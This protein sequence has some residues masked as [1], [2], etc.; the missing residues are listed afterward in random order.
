[1]EIII[2]PSIIALLNITGLF[3]ATEIYQ[4]HAH[5]P[6]IPAEAETITKGRRSLWEVW[7]ERYQSHR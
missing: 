7:S 2:V 5:Q 6:P 1:M 4:Q 3:A